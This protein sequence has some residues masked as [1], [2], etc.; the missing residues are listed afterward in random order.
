MEF[1]TARQVV[2]SRARG[3]RIA[4]LPTRR[5]PKGEAEML[6]TKRYAAALA[7]VVAAL[8]IAAPITDAGAATTPACPCSGAT[9]VGPTLINSVFNHGIV[10]QVS[11]GSTCSSVSG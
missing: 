9:A 8:A 5:R 2:V 11:N 1:T 4:D 3:T 6:T 10:I 7:G